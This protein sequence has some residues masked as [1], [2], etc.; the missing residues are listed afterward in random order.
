MN[1][2]SKN[3]EIIGDVKIGDKVTVCSFAVIKGDEGPIRIGDNS[4]VQE[5]VTLHGAGVSIGKN[6]TIG[7]A[8]TVHG[9]KVGDNVLI[10]MNSVIL[11]NVEI[12]EWSLV[13]AGAV[14]TPGT[15]IPSN[16]LVLGVP[17]KVVREINEGEKKMIE[18]GYKN[19]LRK[20]EKAKDTSE[21]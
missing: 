21:K 14:V 2:I 7:H 18:E 16:S 15:K 12:G 11:N 3:S 4:N 13:G 10:G 17:A 8:A 9:C 20:L 6:V 1:L 19:Y 5:H